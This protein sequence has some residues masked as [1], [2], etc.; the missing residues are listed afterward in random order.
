MKPENHSSNNP[1]TEAAKSLNEMSESKKQLQQ[2][3][4]EEQQRLSSSEVGEIRFFEC[5]VI[6]QMVNSTPKSL[7]VVVK[8]DKRPKTVWLKVAWGETQSL[9]SVELNEG[10]GTRL[11]FIGNSKFASLPRVD[12][13]SVPNLV[14][15][16]KMCSNH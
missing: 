13:Y 5:E 3:I 8:S 9:G 10:I 16:Y 15:Q 11:I 14:E 12:V 2:E 4:Q 7:R 6:A 1:K